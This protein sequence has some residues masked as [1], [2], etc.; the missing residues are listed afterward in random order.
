MCMAQGGVKLCEI[1][2]SMEKVNRELLLIVAANARIRRQ[3]K[4]T[5]VKFKTNRSRWFFKYSKLSD[6]FFF[7]TAGCCECLN[8]RGFQRL[9]KLAQQKN[10]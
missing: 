6:F 4:L 2:R 1:T 8:V 10:L 3:V 7:F 5:D 9:D